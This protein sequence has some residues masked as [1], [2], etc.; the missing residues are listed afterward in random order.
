MSYGSWDE[1]YNTY[2]NLFLGT[3]YDG[4]AKEMM[5][6]IPRIWDYPEFS[7]VVPGTSH[8]MLFLEVPAKETSVRIWSDHP[9]KYL[10]YLSHIEKGDTDKTNVGVTEIIPTI[11]EYLNQ[12]RQEQ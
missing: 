10:V 4:H 11:E 6:L 9:G 2:K 7:D 8:A 12:V 5:S 3:R 1:V